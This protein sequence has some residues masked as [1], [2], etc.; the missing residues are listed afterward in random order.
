MDPPGGPS[1]WPTPVKG[2]TPFRMDKPTATQK[3]ESLAEEMD[4][5]PK[6]PTRDSPETPSPMAFEMLENEPREESEP[7][8]RDKIPE[9]WDTEE[10]VEVEDADDSDPECEDDLN[11]F[12]E[13]IWAEYGVEKEKR[14]RVIMDR[15]MEMVDKFLQ[16]TGKENLG[17]EKYHHMLRVTANGI[18][19]RYK[20]CQQAKGSRA[21]MS[22][23]SYI[24]DGE[25]AIYLLAGTREQHSAWIRCWMFM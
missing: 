13:T 10:E 4:R 21:S 15:T 12:F 6:G 2:F 17:K 24:L 25:R 9:K 20:E 19:K 8:T 5:V 18:T 14:K 22:L 3:R 7:S 1:T 23:S 11:D 16:S